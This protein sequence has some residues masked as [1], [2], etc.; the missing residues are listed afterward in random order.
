MYVFIEYSWYGLKPPPN[1][2]FLHCVHQS[3][4][5]SVGGSRE[6]LNPNI[7]SFHWPVWVKLWY[8]CKWMVNK[9]RLKSDP[10]IFDK[11]TNI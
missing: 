8:P 5:H 6:A 10:K 4:R 1:M 11:L 3:C 2:F 9:N 7:A